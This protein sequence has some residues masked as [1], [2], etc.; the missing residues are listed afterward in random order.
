MAGEQD[1][2]RLIA[3]A[4]ATTQAVNNLNQTVSNVFPQGTAVTSSAGSS[5]GEYLTIIAPNG[6]TYK[7][8][9]LNVS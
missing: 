6:T 2:S 9:L 7:I 8:A 4:Q 5:S 3:A 1:L